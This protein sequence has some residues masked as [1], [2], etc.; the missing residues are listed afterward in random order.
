M[1]GAASL[2]LVAQAGGPVSRPSCGCHGAGT[3]LILQLPLSE[4]TLLVVEI[5]SHCDL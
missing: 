2:L 3:S 5:S 1:D 4:E